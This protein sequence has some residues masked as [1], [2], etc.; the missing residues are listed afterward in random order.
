MAVFHTD[1]PITGDEKKPDRLNR[2]AFARRVGDAL[3]LSRDSNSLVVSLEGPWGYG[4]T[5]V[6]NLINMYYAKAGKDQRPIVFNFNPWMI[7]NANVLVQTFLLQFSSAIG[8]SGRGKSVQKAAKQLI[9][10]SKILNPLKLIPGVEPIAMT[11]E[12]I[13]DGAESVTDKIAEHGDD[14]DIERTREKVVKALRKINKPIVVFIDDLDRLPPVEVFQ[15]IRAVKVVTDFPRTAFLLAFD[16]RYV[17]KALNLYGIEDAGPYLDKIIQVRL[18]LPVISE[19]DLDSLATSEFEALAPIDL[20]S[21]FD[22]DGQRLS[23]LYQ[24]SIKPIVRTPRELKRIFNRLR[25][26]EPSAR[27][28]VCFSDLFALEALAVKAPFVYDHIRANPAA[29]NGEDW[30]HRFSVERPEEVIKKYEDQRNKALETVAQSDRS[31]VKELVGSLFPLV[32]RSAEGS[33]QTDYYYVR[34]RIASPDKL[35]FALSFGLPSGEVPSSVVQDFVQ[36]PGTRGSIIQGMIRDKLLER[37]IELLPRAAEHDSPPDPL[38]YAETLAVLAGSAEVKAIEEKDRDIFEV[39]PVRQLWRLVKSIMK[40]IAANDRADWLLRMAKIPA[41]VVITASALQ[42][43]LR[44]HGF[45]E[46]GEAV[47]EEL[48]WLGEHQLDEM[49]QRWIENVTTLLRENRLFETSEPA[50]IISTVGSLDPKRLAEL[51]QPYLINDETLDRLAKT[52]GEKS[53]VDSIK[54][55]Y[56]KVR[57]DTLELL[58]GA[59]LIRVRVRERM[60]SEIEAVSL[61]AIYNSILTGEPYY[62]VDGTRAER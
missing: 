52:I 56:S 15:M 19:K 40:T 25:F 53:G 34:G 1:S 54:G 28:N 59:E 30:G 55:V 35:G 38:N 58:G 32:R 33:R 27:K 22:D 10:Y 36:N 14:F 21:F 3:R 13:L 42:L 61:R 16:R 45:Y 57:E 60:Q 41:A 26:I 62:L 17:E 20:T 6:I 8:L 47:D 12:A 44:Q 4:K 5:S 31:Y 7:G 37:F 39:S 24:F 43:C 51:M 9:G 29:Y 49:K 48:R 50:R 11:V 46:L 2:L 23:E 18:H